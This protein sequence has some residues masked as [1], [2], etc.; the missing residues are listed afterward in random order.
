MSGLNRDLVTLAYAKLQES[1]QAIALRLKE[2][3]FLAV[4]KLIKQRLASPILKRNNK[5]VKGSP[6]KVYADISIATN[7]LVSIITITII[8]AVVKNIV[9]AIVKAI[10][11]SG[12]TTNTSTKAKGKVKVKEDIPIKKQSYILLGIKILLFII[13]SALLIIFA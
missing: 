6:I 1:F 8:K 3:L 10:A 2:T 11:T 13:A 4:K 12:T 5:G 7:P 9:K